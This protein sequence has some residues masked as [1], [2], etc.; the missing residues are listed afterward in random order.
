MDSSLQQH[1]TSPGERDGGSASPADDAAWCMDIARRIGAGDAAAE[2]SLVARVRPGLLMLLT[3]RC[4]YDAELAADLCQDTLLVV[5][6]RLR[7]R[8][9]ED[10]SKLAAFA[11]QTARQL[12]FDSRRRSALRK[13]EVDSPTIESIQ[14][15]APAEDPVEQASTASLVRKVLEELS[16]DR[17]REVLRRF[18]LLEQGKE[19]ICQAFGIASGTFDQVIFR[20]R[21]RLRSMLQARGA[22]S[23]DLLCGFTFWVPRSWLN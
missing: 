13:T 9:M 2:Q 19:E 3:R 1:S 6:Q 17:D 20:A 10:P 23:R 16:H 22:N 18:Y 12:A 4:A 11:A 14:I 5:L 15:E 7:S 21:A 8:S